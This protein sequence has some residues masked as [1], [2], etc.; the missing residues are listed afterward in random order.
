[1]RSLLHAFSVFFLLFNLIACGDGG[2]PFAMDTS[3]TAVVGDTSSALVFPEMAEWELF[4]LEELEALETELTD[5]LLDPVKLLVNPEEA[6]NSGTLTAQV[7]QDF[8]NRRTIVIKNFDIELEFAS[9]GLVHF[10]LNPNM[11]S[12]GTIYKL[13]KNNQPFGTHNIILNLIVETAEQNLTYN[14][15]MLASDN[16]TLELVQTL[17]ILTFEFAGSSKQIQT[18]ALSAVVPA[19][20]INSDFDPN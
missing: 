4:S 9:V 7:V 12:T 19:Q 11:E 18:L 5:Y 17:P 3:A 10:T 13:N 15:V 6:T 20:L 1:M 14:N 2:G 16:A 8:S